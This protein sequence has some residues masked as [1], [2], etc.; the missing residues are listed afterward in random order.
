LVAEDS[1][2]AAEEEAEVYNRQ[3]I[4]TLI[5]IRTVL[6]FDFWFL[7]SRIFHPIQFSYWTQ[8]LINKF[9]FFFDY[10]EAFE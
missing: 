3:N 10:L 4:R 2:T 5:T 6:I 7:F 1:K 9:G 8:N